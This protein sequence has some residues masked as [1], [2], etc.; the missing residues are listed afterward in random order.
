MRAG[1]ALVT[2]PKAALLMLPFGVWN[3][4]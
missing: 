1:F 3:W 2:N 4:A